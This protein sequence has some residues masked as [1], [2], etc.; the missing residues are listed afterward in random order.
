MMPLRHFIQGEKNKQTQLQ[1]GA[2]LLQNPASRLKSGKP[3]LIVCYIGLYFSIKPFDIWAQNFFSNPF[4]FSEFQQL[5]ETFTYIKSAQYR[6]L[7]GETA[8]F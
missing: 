1:S 8:L 4:S 5:K 2:L 7:H 6:H 3:A